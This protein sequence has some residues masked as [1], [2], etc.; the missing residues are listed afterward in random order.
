MRGYFQNEL[1]DSVIRFETPTQ[2]DRASPQQWENE[3]TPGC[4]GGGSVPRTTKIVYP[5]LC[6]VSRKALS[7]TRTRRSDK[8]ENKDGAIKQKPT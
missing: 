5:S 8:E 4:M 6:S 2:H 7:N 3:I 1:P